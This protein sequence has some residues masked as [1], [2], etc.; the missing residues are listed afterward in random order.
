MRLRSHESNLTDFGSVGIVI[1][2]VIS[3]FVSTYS[4]LCTNDS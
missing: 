4:P 3:L 1:I 2:S